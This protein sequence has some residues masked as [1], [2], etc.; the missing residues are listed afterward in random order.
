[1]LA[2]TPSCASFCIWQFR[3]HES[4]AAIGSVKMASCT[5]V[6][7]LASYHSC[8]VYLRTIF[9][10]C[11]SKCWFEGIKVCYL[12]RAGAKLVP[13]PLRCSTS[14]IRHR[15]GLVLLRPLALCS[16][17][18]FGSE[19]RDPG[20]TP[21]TNQ[22]PHHNLAGPHTLYDKTRIFMGLDLS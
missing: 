9:A 11:Y 10:H 7:C 21:L 19:I 18:V 17:H 3:V 13:V 14:C 2:P 1:M 5:R 22:Q 8:E 4:I 15:T 20:K 16:L 12:L 6:H